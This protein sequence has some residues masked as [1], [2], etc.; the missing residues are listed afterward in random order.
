MLSS[1]VSN[2][3]TS[4]KPNESD[5]S[6]G[7]SD[8]EYP[9][10]VPM[11]SG[12]LP[13]GIFKLDATTSVQVSA[14]SQTSNVPNALFAKD[15][16][17]GA[18]LMAEWFRDHP[19]L[20]EHK[21]VVELAAAAALPSIVA[22]KLKASLV[23][24]TDYP[25][26]ELVSN[27]N[28][29]FAMNNIDTL[30]T[31]P[32]A[33]AVAMPHLWGDTDNIEALMALPMKHTQKK[34][35]DVVLLAEFLWWDTHVQHANILK[36]CD[37]LLNAKG[38]VYCSWSHHNPGRE[39]LDLEFFE[40]AV[41]DY[42]FVVERITSDLRG[43]NDCFDEDCQQPSYLAKMT[44]GGGQDGCGEGSGAGPA[45]AAPQQQVGRKKEEATV[46]ETKRRNKSEETETET[47]T[48]DSGTGQ[49]RTQEGPHIQHGK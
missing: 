36:S 32:K 47:E 42:G 38:I 28:K 12:A 45:A 29:Q 30:A 40:R 19:G 15:I 17:Y 10:I 34:G 9:N 5:S 3:S 13:F 31:C 14:S 37:A 24:A 11:F 39:H 2:V 26:E 4:S 1:N 6:D 27:M 21:S 8:T 41:R 7:D 18:V 49:V 44:R 33:H 46:S 20:L 22:Y 48:E 25:N 23:V 43:Y 16:W 35:F